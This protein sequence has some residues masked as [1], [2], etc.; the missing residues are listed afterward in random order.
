MRN[1]GA[2]GIRRGG[3]SPLRLV[4]RSSAGWQQEPHVSQER[5]DYPANAIDEVRIGV[6]CHLRFA[7]SDLMLTLQH[8]C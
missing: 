1:A 3:P 5:V 7:T 6:A 8:L 4:S 2:L